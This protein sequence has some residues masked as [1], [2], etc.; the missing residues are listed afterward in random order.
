MADPLSITMAVG[1]L[2]KASYTVAAYLTKITKEV[3]NAPHQAAVALREVEEV[4]VILSQLQAFILRFEEA[5]RSRTVLVQVDQVVVVLSGCVA[6]FSELEAVLDSVP[7]TDM[8]LF[9]RIN[10]YRKETDISILIDRLQIHKTSL[11]LLLIIL[12]GETIFD[13]SESVAALK[14]SVTQ[15]YQDM[16][17]RLP[18]SVDQSSMRRTVAPSI[19]ASD[20]AN[21]IITVKQNPTAQ[22]PS[23]DLARHYDFEPDLRSSRPYRKIVFDGLTSAIS[24]KDSHTT[25]WSFLSGLSLADVSR[26]SVISLVTHRSEIYNASHYKVANFSREEVDDLFPKS[27][28]WES[29]YHKSALSSPFHYPPVFMNSLG[30][31]RSYRSALNNIDGIPRDLSSA[32]QPQWSIF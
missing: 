23:K 24:I 10:W 12:T 9:D 27:P 6:T 29:L 13:L 17:Q 15:F 28:L 22:Y 30:T 32:K 26:I 4:S 25:S 21:S 20:D 3:A 16:S 31:L 2:I 7:T 5:D 14:E 8:K 11:S 19:A 18:L 1:G